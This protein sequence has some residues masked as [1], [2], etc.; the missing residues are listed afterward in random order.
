[1]MRTPGQATLQYV[2]NPEKSTG[3]TLVA[4]QKSPSYQGPPP[5]YS[6][7][8]ARPPQQQQVQVIASRQTFSL[9]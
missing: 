6:V 7:A 4:R 9:Q 8:N 2:V 1:M 3:Q 5:S